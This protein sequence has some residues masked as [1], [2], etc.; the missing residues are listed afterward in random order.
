MP[1]G[2]GHPGRCFRWC[3]GPGD[4]WTVRTGR[5][6]A[7]AALAAVAVT[8]ALAPVALAAGNTVQMVDNEPDLTNWHF[9][10]ADLTV[11]AGTT[12]VWHNRGEEE[13]SVTADAK[14]FDSGLKK[15][16]TNFQWTFPRGGV[17]AYHSQPPP[18][19]VAK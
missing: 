9:D 19:M 1:A 8:L 10:P 18:R 4:T 15:Q 5:W 17:Y 14:S 7:L 3:P 13:H 11:P 16:G 6:S 12:V 2:D